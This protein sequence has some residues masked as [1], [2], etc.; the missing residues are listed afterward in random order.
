MFSEPAPSEQTHGWHTAAA[1]AAVNTQTRVD[2][3]E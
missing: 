1:A 3:Y 2:N